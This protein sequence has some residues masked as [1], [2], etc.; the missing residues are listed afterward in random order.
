MA[1]AMPALTGTVLVSRA[2]RVKG[3]EESS[4]RVVMPP[5]SV[6]LWYGSK[7]CLGSA[8]RDSTWCGRR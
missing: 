3:K 2:V 1:V 7:G 4:H 6:A 5:P 8:S